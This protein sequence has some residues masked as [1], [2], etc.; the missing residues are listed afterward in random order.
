MRGLERQGAS[1]CWQILISLALTAVHWVQKAQQQ[2]DYE[3]CGRKQLFPSGEKQ[4][5]LC[6]GEPLGL[7]N[8]VNSCDIN[9]KHLRVSTS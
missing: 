5:S 8:K 7:W 4:V 6:R 3:I 1:L 9:L 2:Q